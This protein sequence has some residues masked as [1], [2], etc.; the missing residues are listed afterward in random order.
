[1]DYYGEMAKALEKMNDYLE[2]LPSFLNDG[3]ETFFEAVEE[4]SARYKFLCTQSEKTLGRGNPMS[5]SRMRLAQN[6][7]LDLLE[8]GIN[9]LQNHKEQLRLKACALVVLSHVKHPG[10][11][12][13]SL[14]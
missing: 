14:N 7:A 8:K 9:L 10:L 1:M 12:E 5:Y 2:L 13:V 3:L 4:K 6:K 11:A